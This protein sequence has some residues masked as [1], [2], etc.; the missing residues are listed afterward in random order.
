MGKHLKRYLAMLILTVGYGTAILVAKLFRSPRPH[1]AANKSR[2]IL[3]IGTFHNPNWFY[4]HLEPLA[5]CSSSQIVLI[6]DGHTGTVENLK[7]ITPRRMASRLLSRAGAKFVWSIGYAIR[8]RPDFYMGYAIFPAATTALLLGRLFRRPACF[9]VTSG[10]LELE[11]GGYRAENRI[12]AALGA[13]SAWIERLATALTRE[14]E[15]LIVRGGQ[16]EQYIRDFGAENR[17]EIITGSVAIPDACP[18]VAE[19]SIDLIFVGRLTER[20]RPHRFLDVVERVRRRV[21]GLRV[22]IVGDGPDSDSLAA[23]IHELGLDGQVELLG[24]RDDVL[25]LNLDAKLFVLTSRWEG[26]SIA[27]LEA[28]A[29]GTIPVVSDV[30]DLRD[31]IEQG[32]NGYIFDQDDC[33][34]FAAV[35]VELL[36]DREKLATLSQAARQT[37]ADRCSRDA[38]AGRWQETLRD[39][40]AVN[41]RG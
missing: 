25:Q 6:A 1:A 28:M 19:R 11:G 36:Q 18:P 22:A 38:I 31:V 23:R 32:Q 21:G 4:A 5:R 34:A 24:L 17:I 29:C 20:K 39:T 7:V 26:V 35:I 27:M 2:Q 10:P 13:P 33:D 9:Q 3:V 37:V 12:L 8:Y 40:G 30:G 41:Y 15:L 16:A 14:F